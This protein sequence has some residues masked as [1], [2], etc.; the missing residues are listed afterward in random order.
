MRRGV[1]HLFFVGIGGTGMNGIAEVLI[2]LGYEVSGSDL[3]E[4]PALA[5]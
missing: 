1:R 5:R 4:G 3:R 2:N